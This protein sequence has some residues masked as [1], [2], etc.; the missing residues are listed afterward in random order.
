[1]VGGL[2]RVRIKPLPGLPSTLQTIVTRDLTV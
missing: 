2:G 1:M